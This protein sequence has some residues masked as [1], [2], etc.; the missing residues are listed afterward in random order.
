MLFRFLQVR[1]SFEGILDNDIMAINH[2]KDAASTCLE[3]ERGI[4]QR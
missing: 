4:G 2:Q 1:I 3:S